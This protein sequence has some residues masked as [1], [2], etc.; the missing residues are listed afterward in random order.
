MF[1]SQS[2]IFLFSY[3][4]NKKKKNDFSKGEIVKTIILEN[5]FKKKNNNYIIEL[6]EIKIENSN[7]LI[8]R[9]PYINIKK[10][11]YELKLKIDRDETFIFNEK[12]DLNANCLTIEEEFNFYYKFIKIDQDNSKI[13]LN[14][15]IKSIFRILRG[16]KEH[17]TFSLLLTIITEEEINKNINVYDIEKLL[18]N[19]EKIGDISK[20]NI[21][22]FFSKNEHLFFQEKVH[23]FTY[24]YLL[25]ILLTNR[26]ELRVFINDKEK[27]NFIFDCLYKF[28]KL[29]K[30]Y[31]EII[32][33]YPFL[34]DAAYSIKELL[35]IFFYIK[36][37][38]EFIFLLDNNKEHIF[39]LIFK[40]ERDFWIED[41]IKQKDGIFNENFD[42]SFYISLININEYIINNYKR[43]LIIGFKRD[44][45]C[46]NFIHFILFNFF[47]SNEIIDKKYFMKYIH[48]YSKKKLNE[49]NNME[50]IGLICIFYQLRDKY[51]F[52]IFE[53]LITI[54]NKRK[55]S[56]EYIK[57][58]KKIDC[59]KEFE[60]EDIIFYEKSIS[61]L[62]ERIYNIKLHY[63]S[64][65]ANI[66]KKISP[67]IE[68]PY[69]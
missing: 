44:S 35:I 41:F 53:E 23:P 12:K 32:P 9:D 38:S 49:M 39:Q 65:K 43:K 2:L 10:D 22:E 13:L 33:D 66:Q 1:Y 57:Y 54:L 52:K 34:I 64:I 30:N 3:E 18:L 17:S 11:N 56:D 62:L 67:K 6:Y 8:F 68:F 50:I 19:T 47:F 16:N 31:I 51:S 69:F 24:F 20:I 58:L 55:I 37:L 48:K 5:Q 46:G 45:N 4:L 25:Y 60:E 40:D 15:L 36:N 27:R 59:N 63:I 42:E 7:I 21:N 14:L 26:H 28:K 29:L 61:I